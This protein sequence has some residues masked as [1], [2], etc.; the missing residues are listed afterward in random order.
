MKEIKVLGTGCPKCA[1]LEAENREI[2][3]ENKRILEENIEFKARITGL[4]EKMA[5][6]LEV[7]EKKSQE[8]SIKYGSQ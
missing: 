1:K 4:E 7:T 3:R 6:L 2:R 8:P 5:K